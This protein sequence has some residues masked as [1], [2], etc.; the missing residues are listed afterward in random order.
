MDEHEAGG[1]QQ[2]ESAK[3]ESLASRPSNSKTQN[4]YFVDECGSVLQ[5]RRVGRA[6]RHEVSGG[7]GG[8]S[9]GERQSDVDRSSHRYKRLLLPGYRAWLVL[10]L[11]LAA[12]VYTDIYSG[13][14][15]CSSQEG[16]PL[17]PHRTQTHAPHAH[18][19]AHV[20]MRAR[21]LAHIFRFFRGRADVAELA[22]GV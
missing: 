22:C 12:C 19:H 7:S 20:P 9:D 13:D 5:R 14:T 8:G 10:P 6:L 16:M 11:F 21:T 15:A 3:L 4:G 2:P 18:A 1:H 17:A